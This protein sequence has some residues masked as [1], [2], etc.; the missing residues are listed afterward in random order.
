MFVGTN[1]ER[2][3]DPKQPG[4]RG[5]L[6]AFRETDGEFL[7]QITHEKLAAGRVNDWPF[8][9]VASSPLVEGDR[10]YYVSNRGELMCARHRGLPRRR[11]ER[12]AVQGREAHRARTTATSSG[13]ST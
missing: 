7:W 4:D 12:R 10:L 13:S 5:V 2:L 1:N 6:M 11:R 3:R 8:Q 9:G